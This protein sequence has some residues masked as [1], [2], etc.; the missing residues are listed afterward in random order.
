ML[1]LTTNLI[2]RS[3]VD[4]RSKLDYAQVLKRECWGTR[5]AK[6]ILFW[7]NLLILPPH[8][9]VLR[10]Y[11]YI[12]VVNLRETFPNEHNQGWG[13]AINNVY[14]C[15]IIITPRGWQSEVHNISKTSLFGIL[16][17]EMGERNVS[18]L[19]LK[20][21]ALTPTSLN[22]AGKLKFGM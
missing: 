3:G 9:L 17:R 13:S 16:G 5:I 12:L 6:I 21:G 10:S 1:R 4:F 7:N 22:W 8:P 19:T 20:K 14:L 2:F 15:C 11:H 18:F